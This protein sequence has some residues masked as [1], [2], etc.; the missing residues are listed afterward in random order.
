MFSILTCLW[1]SGNFPTAAQIPN[2]LDS[3]DVFLKN[4]TARDS[5]YARALNRTT[6]KLIYE[7]AAYERADSL[8]Q[9][10]EVLCR[11]IGWWTGVIA[12]YNIRATRYLLTNQPANALTNFR[13]AVETAQTHNA[14]KQEIFDLMANVSVA[15]GKLEQWPKVMENSL[16]AIRF[17]EQYGLIPRANAWANV[18]DAL[19]KM[20]KQREALPYFQRALAIEKESGNPRNE[21]IAENELGNSYEGLGKLAIALSHYRIALKLAEKVDFELLQTDILTN[22]A[23][24]L[25]QSKHPADGLPLA[26]KALRIARQQENREAMYTAYIVIG[27]LYESLKENAKAEAAYKEALANAESTSQRANAQDA[28]QAL[29]EFYAKQQNYQQ[30]YAFQVEKNRLVDSAANVRAEV[31]VHRLLTQYQTE[32]K[33]AQIKVL[34][35]QA[36]LHDKEAERIRLQNNA[37]SIGSLLVLLLAG[38]ASAWL[39]NR[40]K[41]RRLE[42]AQRLRQQIAHDLHDEVGSTLSSISLLSGMV[43]NLIAQNRPERIEQAIHKINTD[44]RQ[45][46]ESVDEIIWTINPGN[47][48]LHRIALRLQEYAQPLMESKNIHFD[49]AVDATLDGFPVSMEVRR[50][51]YLIGKEAINNLVKYSQATKA[52]LRFEQQNGQLKVLIEDDGQ[53]FDVAR[54]TT[55]T[56]RAS[57]QQRATDMGGTLA[58]Q[59]APGQGT[60]LQ[61]VVGL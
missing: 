52:T 33:E 57:M 61:L 59:S 21:A 16:K 2:S 14:P 1:L 60:S 19:K 24:V 55:R 15:Y 30:A 12:V 8:S 35:Q 54:P 38:T 43:K 47:D 37:L 27:Q 4:Y 45:I 5:V 58:I 49:F 22:I 42:E 26:Q 56:G 18:G 46:L 23:R 25:D 9:R 53:G 50:N 48:T 28:R 13:K 44:A 32:K 51:L 29:T 20:G 17:Q 40:A 39:L 31:A 6:R 41:L 36:Q 11:Q 34:R 10:S 7:K 3:L